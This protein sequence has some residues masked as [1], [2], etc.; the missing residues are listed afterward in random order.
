MDNIFNDKVCL[1]QKKNVLLRSNFFIF[2][3]ATNNFLIMNQS[4]NAVAMDIMSDSR[5]EIQPMQIKAWLGKHLKDGLSS[6]KSGNIST[7]SCMSPWG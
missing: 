4:N 6:G 7:M 5:L 1:C 2:N 3:R